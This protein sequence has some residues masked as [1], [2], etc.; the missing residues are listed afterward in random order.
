MCSRSSASWERSRL[1]SPG[2]HSAWHSRSCARRFARAGRSESRTPATEF[3]GDARK[4]SDPVTPNY[5][6]GSLSPRYVGPRG[7]IPPVTQPIVEG[8][9]LASITRPI[10]P[11]ALS[12]RR[13]SQRGVVSGTIGGA[14]SGKLIE[15]RLNAASFPPPSPRSGEINGKRR[16]KLTRAITQRPRDYASAG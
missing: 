9:A 7:G 16:W 2:D 13:C 8:H 4:P 15:I 5:T 14:C 10:F 1:L 11:G 12:Y 3:L 6:E